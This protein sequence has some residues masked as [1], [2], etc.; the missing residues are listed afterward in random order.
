MKKI[1]QEDIRT[2]IEIKK[3]WDEVYSGKFKKLDSNS[4][5]TEI[6]RW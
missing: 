3:A 2:F 1:S 5:L 4:F 6:V